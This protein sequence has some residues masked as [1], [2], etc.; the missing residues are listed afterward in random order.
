MKYGYEYSID[1]MGWCVYKLDPDGFTMEYWCGPLESKEL[2]KS[3]A[4]RLD[5][6][7]V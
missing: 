5:G 3:E 4:K 1:R 2:A 6:L 7:E